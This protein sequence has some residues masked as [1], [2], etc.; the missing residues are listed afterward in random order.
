M[1]NP[2]DAQER[3]IADGDVVRI[4]NDRGQILAG[5]VV[6]D[7]VRP[8]VVRMCEGAWYD[9]AEPGVPGALC[10]HGDV[11]VLTLDKGTSKLAQGNCAHTVLAQIEK[12][13]GP[14]PEVTAFKPYDG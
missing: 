9:P 8:S 12:F 4:F 2:K 1:I 6:T 7:M 11:N 13:T 3:G 10:K 5:V 14:L